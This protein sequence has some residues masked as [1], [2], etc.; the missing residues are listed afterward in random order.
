[1]DI[2]FIIIGIAV[3]LHGADNLTEGA[4]NIA[5]RFNM[6]EL[7]IGLTVVAFGTSM[8]E[9]CVSLASAINGTADMAV[10]NVVGSN[11][12]NIFLIVGVCAMI[13][14]M[15]VGMA[16]IR[17][18]LPYA[19]IATL[20]LIFFLVDGTLTKGEAL[21]MLALFMLYM[22]HT[23]RNAK[24]NDADSK[25]SASETTVKRQPSRH[26]TIVTA[27]LKIYRFPAFRII[28]GLAELI[29]GSDV[30]VGHAVSLATTLGVSEAVIGITILGA[31]TSL[32]ELA[33]SVVAAL[34]GS[35]SMALGNVIG[36]C[37][38]NILMI[39][40]VTGVVTPLS[41]Q[42]ITTTDLACL[43][44]GALLLWFFSFTKSTMERWE[45]CVL[46]ASFGVYMYLLLA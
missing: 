31:G 33:T 36:S 25:P 39:L 14:P 20:M 42:G 44:A 5:R 1:M 3:V 46:T 26:G 43:F 19:F 10:G 41:P 13:H 24:Q 8:P 45:G 9:M 21:I 32:P 17:R 35:T 40:G 34:K 30:F 27:V 15:S 16:A 22:Y 38:F 29:I 12:F 4:V 23:L 2:L 11:I 18:D 6:T 28:L 37:L 7:V